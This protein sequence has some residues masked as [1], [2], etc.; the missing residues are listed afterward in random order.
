M[1]STNLVNHA[2][3]FLKKA[4]EL[5]LIAEIDQRIEERNHEQRLELIE[6]LR[7]LPTEEQSGL[8]D[9]TKAAGEALLEYQRAEA[10]LVEARKKMHTAQMQ[11]YGAGLQFEGRRAGLE[12]EIQALAPAFVREAYREISWLDENVRHKVSFHIVSYWTFLG[13]K[14]EENSNAEEVAA[15]RGELAAARKRLVDMLS[16]PLTLHD[17][18]MEVKEMCD[19]LLKRS[20]ELGVDQREFNA[21]YQKKEPIVTVE[22]VRKAKQAKRNF[23]LKNLTI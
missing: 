3:E 13:P 18:E 16:E 17:M 19:R 14:K 1:L 5:G 15:F 8:A 20:I 6:K 2:S 23:E 4:E 12:R 11:A 21:R 10:Y 22:T 7:A 9:L